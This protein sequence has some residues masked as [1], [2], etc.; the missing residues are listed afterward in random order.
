MLQLFEAKVLPSFLTLV[1][2]Y[3]QLLEGLMILEGIFVAR[4]AKD[5]V[6]RKET[7]MAGARIAV[8][9]GIDMSADVA[10]VE[11][12]FGY[13][14]DFQARDDILSVVVNT[15][16]PSM[17]RLYCWLGRATASC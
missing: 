9:I 11:N 13:M 7:D 3:L 5:Q 2:F 12:R 16:M 1:L 14:L 8:D 6:V 17:S 10:V 15:K 4:A